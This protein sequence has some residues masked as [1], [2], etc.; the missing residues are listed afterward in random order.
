MCVKEFLGYNCGH[1]SVP[2]LRR[3]PLT[4]LNASFPDCE[5]A[6]ERPLFINENCHAC[7]R[8]L[9]NDRVLK[10]EESHRA[11]HHAG[12]CGCPVIFDGG[13]RDSHRLRPRSSKGKGKG[14]EVS[15]S[16]EDSDTAK[17]EGGN[18]EHAAQYP[19]GGYEGQGR[20]I[21]YQGQQD[22][23]SSSPHVHVSGAHH[24]MS[25]NQELSMP[26]QMESPYEHPGCYDAQSRAVIDNVYD[27]HG[28]PEGRSVQH[29]ALSFSH[30]AIN[31]PGRGMKWYPEYNPNRANIPQFLTG[32]A[33]I[34]VPYQVRQRLSTTK[35]A[36]ARTSRIPDATNSAAVHTL[37]SPIT[38]QDQQDQEQ[39]PNPTF[40]LAAAPPPALE[41]SAQ[42]PVAEEAN[43]Q[44]L[45]E[46]A[47]P[48][49]DNVSH[50][51]TSH[52]VLQIPRGPR[53]W[54]SRKKSKSFGGE[55]FSHHSIVGDTSIDI[56]A[57]DDAGYVEVDHKSP[58]VV[59][60][61]VVDAMPM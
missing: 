8:I 53:A 11:R 19:V 5:Y 54:Q 37:S 52:I 29:S 14:K 40:N 51:P 35:T 57:A 56:K 22:V 12:E 15:L 32:T 46:A 48:L 34:A 26:G 7:T 38:E 23:E 16:G 55:K 39:V 44:T 31:Q 1:C 21:R 47:A 9:W 6:A 33:P 58:G 20:D 17:R 42:A 4:L 61:G 49:Q 2:H 3:C 13:N 41:A 60:S 25:I 10:E 45:G 24:P 28:F 43:A 30:L 18:G 59:S 50:P 27:R 36:K